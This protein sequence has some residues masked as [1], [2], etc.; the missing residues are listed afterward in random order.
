MNDLITLQPPTGGAFVR[1]GMMRITSL[2][3]IFL[4]LAHAVAFPGFAR[5]ADSPEQLAQDLREAVRAKDA[6]KF[7]AALSTET[8][9]AMAEAEAATTRLAAARR[10]AVAAIGKRFDLVQWPDRPAT[11]EIPRGFARMSDIEIGDIDLPAPD[12][13]MLHVKTMLRDAQKPGRTEVDVLPAIKEDGGWKIDLSELARNQ[14]ATADRRAAL[15]SEL[16]QA[17]GSGKISDRMSAF[18][19]AMNAA[20]ATGG[21]P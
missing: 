7:A 10:E 2:C 13:A 18:N 19:G 6:G 21:R 5:A 17:I 11:P 9:R 12:R 4:V 16:T 1:T 3:F 14:A 15:F 20:T 8:Q